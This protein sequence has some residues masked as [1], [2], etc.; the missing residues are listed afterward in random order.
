MFGSSILEAPTESVSGRIA[1][2]LVTNLD[3][4]AATDQLSIFTD[5]VGNTGSHNSCF[6]TDKTKLTDD[7][8]VLGIDHGDS[9]F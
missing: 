1:Q 4:R 6:T 7:L 3:S 8:F 5:G 2:N 9:Y